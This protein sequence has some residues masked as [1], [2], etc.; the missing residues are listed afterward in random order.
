MAFNRRTFPGLIMTQDGSTAFVWGR[1][2]DS[3]PVHPAHIIS[4]PANLVSKHTSGPHPEKSAPS[5]ACS[6]WVVLVFKQNETERHRL[7]L[8]NKH[9]ALFSRSTFAVLRSVASYTIIGFS[10]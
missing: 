7:A 6:G 10:S 5:Q 8:Y 2:A 9:L 3:I 1:S 4:T